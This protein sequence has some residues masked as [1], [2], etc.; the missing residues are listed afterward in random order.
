MLL[1]PE[2]RSRTPLWRPFRVEGRGFFTKAL[3]PSGVAGMMV[4]TFVDP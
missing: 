2:L 4:A 1:T 3:K